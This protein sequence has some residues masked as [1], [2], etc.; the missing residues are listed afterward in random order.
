MGEQQPGAARAGGR[1]EQARGA[2][3]RLTTRMCLAT[4]VGAGLAAAL[5]TGCGAQ[6]DTADAPKT[7]AGKAAPAPGDPSH[8][9]SEKGSASPSSSQTGKGGGDNEDALST[10]GSGGRG[11]GGAS[12]GKPGSGSSDDGAAAHPCDSQNLTINVTARAGA[13]SQRVIETRNTGAAACSLSSSPGVDLGNS[14]SPDQSKNIK[15][16]LASGT[17]R[18]PVPAGRSAYTVIDLNPSGARGGGAA[19]VDELNV[20]AD[21]EGTNMPLAATRNFPLGGDARVV[22]PTMGL[23]QSSVAEA[24]TSLASAGE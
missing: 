23:Y 20:L 5:L 9:S 24:A 11:T 16:I 12:G 3:R 6:D 19:D 18:F 21:Q 22:N 14:G 17:S 1:P 10:S 4:A 15:P 2:R 8:S 7:V 13:P